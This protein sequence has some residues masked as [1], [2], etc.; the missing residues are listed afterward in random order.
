M[1][2]DDQR[3]LPFALRRASVCKLPF[4]LQADRVARLVGTDIPALRIAFL[5][6][7]LASLGD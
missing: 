5:H 3:C 2:S 7:A 1:P 6:L 4:D